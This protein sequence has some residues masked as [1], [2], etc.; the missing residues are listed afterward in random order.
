MPFKCIGEWLYSS[1]I[2]NITLDG[3]QWSAL[4]PCCFATWKQTPSTYCIRGWVELRASLDVMNLL[5]LP[6]I[7]PS[8][9]GHPA[10]SL[11]EGLR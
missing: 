6:G 2:L 8:V 10:C 3:G 4:Q 7:E 1:I 9:L 11:V 5:L